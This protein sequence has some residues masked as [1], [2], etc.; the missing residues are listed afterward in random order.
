M[1]ARVLSVVIQDT[2]LGGIRK[3]AQQDLFINPPAQLEIVNGEHHFDTF[4]EVARHPVGTAQVNLWFAGVLEVV[5]A[6]VLQEPADDAAYPYAMAQ[7]TNTGPQCASAAH[8]QI[9]LHTGLGSPVERLD[10]SWVKKSVDFSD[11]TRGPL[12]TRM[13]S[14]AIDQF[15]ATGS[16]I[17]RGHKQ[18]PVCAALG[19]RGKK[20]EDRLYRLRES[21]ISSEQAQ[22]SVESRGAGVVVSSSQMGISADFAI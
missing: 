2:G 21:R 13:G 5:N 17:H 22:I 4:I 19:A 7:P 6:T 16:Q 15:Y 18:R 10:D 20:I 8:D 1:S 12:P 9:D 11:D 14:L 3:V